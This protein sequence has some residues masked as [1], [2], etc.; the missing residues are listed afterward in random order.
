M[1]K[2]NSED[3]ASEE[4]V[5]DGRPCLFSY[6]ARSIVPLTVEELSSDEDHIDEEA[7]KY[8]KNLRKKQEVSDTQWVDYQEIVACS[9]LLVNN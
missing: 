7:L 5:G 1:A 3:E 9:V 6:I 2:E 4:E 8:M